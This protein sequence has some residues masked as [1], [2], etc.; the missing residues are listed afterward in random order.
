M[1]Q[2]SQLEVQELMVRYFDGL[3][4]SDSAVLRSVFHADLMYVNATR[5]N[6]ENM[7]LAAYMKRIDARTPPSS[8]GD[9]RNEVIERVT[10]HG[11]RIG[12]VEA[13][14]TMMG[15]DYQDLLTLIH[16]TEGWRVLTKVF[17]YIERGEAESAI[18]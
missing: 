7:G 11:G 10:L 3:Y 6:Y 5:G 2:D 12:I 15:R 4:R 16:T 17:S 18:R 13:R 8:R 1:K 14:M 9:P